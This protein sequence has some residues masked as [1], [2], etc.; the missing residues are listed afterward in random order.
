[1][2]CGMLASF[3]LCWSHPLGALAVGLLIGLMGPP[4]G[5]QQPLYIEP[6]LR[7]APTT[8][9]KSRVAI[10]IGFGIPLLATIGG[11]WAIR[12]TPPGVRIFGQIMFSYLIGVLSVWAVATFAKAPKSVEKHNKWLAGMSLGNLE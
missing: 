10:V 2:P 4:K 8:L 3:V 7:P 9:T 6:A 11:L 5:R 1:M 12:E